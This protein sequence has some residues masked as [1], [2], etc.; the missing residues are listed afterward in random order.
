MSPS[1]EYPSPECPCAVI[2]GPDLQQLTVYSLWLQNPP[3]GDN[4]NVLSIL[5]QVSYLSCA[6]TGDVADIVDIV[7]INAYNWCHASDTYQTR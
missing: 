6:P 7:G 5:R 3:M 1:P 2:N 4:P